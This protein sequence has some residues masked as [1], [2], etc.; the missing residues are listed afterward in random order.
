MTVKPFSKDQAL[1]KVKRLVEN[2]K[3]NESEY[4]K[5]G[6]GYNETEVRRDFIDPFFEALGWDVS[7]KGGL[8]QHTREVIHEDSVDV[9]DQN[10]KPDY[11]FRA[12][13]IRKY[14]VEAKKPSVKIES[15]SK[16]SFQLKRYGWSAKMPVSVLTNFNYLIIY[17]CRTPPNEADDYRIGRLKQYHYTEFVNKFDEIYNALSR[18]SV[19]SGKFDEIYKF[20][21][22]KGVIQIDSFFLSQIEKWRE[23]LAKEILIQNPNIVQSELNY[24]V[25]TFLNR[26]VFLRI[27]EDRNLEKYETLLKVKPDDVY[28]EFLTLCKAADQKYNSGLFNFTKDVLSTKISLG[29]SVLR[30]I[31]AELYYPKS[32]YVFSVIETNLL[33]DIYEMFLSKEIVIKN[34]KTVEVREKPEIANEKGVVTT[35]KFIIDAIISKSLQKLIEGKS[36]N[37]ISKMHFADICC[38]SGAFLIAAFQYLIDYHIDWYIS[39]GPEK[40]KDRV[41]KGTGNSWFLTLEEKRRIL[42]NNIFGVDIDEN[43]VEVAKFGLLI[44]ILEGETNESIKSLYDKSH[45]KALPDLDSNI[46]HG[47]SL[48]DKNIFKFKKISEMK[49]GELDSLRVFNWD[50]KFPKIFVNGGFDAIIGNPP[51]SRIQTMKK[52]SPLE[53]DYFQSK[54][55]RYNT[56]SS[57]NFDKYFVFIERAVQLLRNNGMLG[58]ITP[59]KFMKIRSGESLRKLIS[60]NSYLNEIVYFG[61]EQVFGGKTTTY[62]AILVLSKKTNTNFKVEF[63]TDITSWKL[64]AQGFIATMKNSEISKD[65]WIFITGPLKKLHQRL[66]KI[67]TTLQTVAEIYVGLQTSMDEVYII[68]PE[69]IS[70]S[71]VSFKDVKGR[72]CTIEKKILKPCIYNLT[73]KPY[74]KPF[75]NTLIIFPYHNIGGN[76]IAYS[77]IEMKTKFPKALA[78]LNQFKK[79]LAKRDISS[80]DR[81][82]WYR[83]GRSQSLTKFKG[84]EK[85]VVKVLSLEPVFAYD[86][87]D[88]MFTGGG[89]GPYYGVSLKKDTKFSIHYLQA[90]LNN[91]I[92]DLFVKK[93][94]SV[95]RGGYFSYGKQFIQNLPIISPDL[96]NKKQK[97]I[98][99]E[100]VRL[101]KKLISL[102]TKYD[103]TTVPSKR[104]VLETQIEAFKDELDSHVYQLYQISEKERK[105]LITLESGE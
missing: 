100:I 13:G 25:Q 92:T 47:N 51:Y 20:V 16:S 50:E 55:S 90:L 89:N 22:A 27:C 26:L 10:K 73:L 75:A 71:L 48:V 38:G 67:K 58:Y 56:A 33:G 68:K 59:H 31:I 36:P 49:S 37:D 83:Y 91:P 54:H 60:E 99:D 53:L 46:Q 94:S 35:P 29:N 52:I 84:R 76:L 81:N 23:R 95:F 32:P 5:N 41:Y 64:G 43:A 74:S 40:H 8:S 82:A 9:E 17:D 12:G 93:S 18:E 45:V 104:K 72:Q 7:N 65:P 105:Y 42:T 69:K 103:R 24:V 3:H 96:S 44:K 57:D 101:V 85:L 61:K 80:K 4:T 66:K 86:D 87:N 62:T 19:Y 78:Y 97:Q 39:D 15:D 70:G 34:K 2:F 88:L 21:E 30:K 98:H 14:F 102:N 11:A 28:N 77:L 1:E 79:E 63:V 6:S